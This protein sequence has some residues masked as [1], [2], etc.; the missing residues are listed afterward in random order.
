ME[1]YI[2]HMLQAT[3]KSIIDIYTEMYKKGYE[4]KFI[5]LDELKHISDKK[6]YP[7]NGMII[8]HGAIPEREDARVGLFINGFKYIYYNPCEN[9]LID[10]A[11][12]PSLNR[13]VELPLQHYH[14][15]FNQPYSNVTDELVIK[16][17]TDC[18]MNRRVL[19]NL[20]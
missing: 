17:L 15:S 2:W 4:V 14:K 1:Y 11:V 6:Y 12:I 19:F 20:K 10:I 7:K 3:R 5:K 8:V 18:N 16:F 13:Y 9:L